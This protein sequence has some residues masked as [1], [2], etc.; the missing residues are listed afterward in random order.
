MAE[1]LA[2]RAAGLVAVRGPGLCRPESS[3]FP[4]GP[5]VVGDDLVE[6]GLVGWAGKVGGS[7]TA[8]P[9]RLSTVALTW[10]ALASLSSLLVG[11]AGL[12]REAAD[13]GGMDNDRG[14]SQRF[15]RCI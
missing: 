7:G 4:G 14:S 13:T 11:P 12:D 1:M 3:Q 15:R 6:V 5:E 2:W 10:R 9:G 8:I